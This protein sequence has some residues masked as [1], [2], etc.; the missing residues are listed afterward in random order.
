M[1]TIAKR[2]I[3]LAVAGSGALALTACPAAGPTSTDFAVK[4][5]EAARKLQTGAGPH[6]MAI[7]DGVLVQANPKG[8]NIN[9]F[10]VEKEIEIKTLTAADLG[11]V[12]SG[13]ASASPGTTKATHDGHY[14]LTMDPA[15]PGLRVLKPA[16]AKQV[17][18][19]NIAPYKASSKLVWADDTT[20]YL[21]ATSDTGGVNV[22]KL[23]WKNGFEQQPDQEPLNV[24]RDGVAK[25]AGGNIG[26]GG[27]FLAMPNGTDNSVSFIKLGTAGVT[28]LQLGN[29]PGPLDIAMVDGKTI[30][31]YG[32]K[33]SNTFV[34]YDLAA[35]TQLASIPVGSTPS[36]MLVRSDGK[37]MYGTCRGSANVCVIDTVNAKLLTEIKVGLGQ[38]DLPANPVHIFGA[39]GPNG[40]EQA[41]VGDDG[42]GSV[43]VID[44]QANRAIAVIKTG[45]GHHKMA[46]TKTKA[47]VSNLTDSTIAVIDRSEIK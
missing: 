5:L 38:A 3:S 47:F 42:D 14:T 6:G 26:L 30:L 19:V 18:T 29:N 10:D 15:I 24:T 9:L 23:S 39:E 33:N 34:L 40:V 32:N 27:G 35:K 1:K 12:L 28:S 13:V 21:S 20:A 43:T 16:E 36:D 22:I 45:V 41:W 37:F 2:A 31:G 44:T 11:T 8:G 17:A 46:F 4:Q 7:A 25:G